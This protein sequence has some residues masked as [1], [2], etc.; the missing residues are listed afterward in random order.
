MS[1]CTGAFQIVRRE[2]VVQLK[3]K[4]LL[5]YHV[6]LKINRIAWN[7]LTAL[8]TTTHPFSSS[9]EPD[10]GPAL[11]RGYDSPVLGLDTLD[12]CLCS[13]LG[14]K[15][16]GVWVGE[17]AILLHVDVIC[18]SATLNIADVIMKKKVAPLTLVPHSVV[19]EPVERILVVRQLDILDGTVIRAN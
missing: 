2:L 7:T 5:V 4:A 18:V 6:S 8:W 13:V 3:E 1:A 17:Q 12:N 9:Q 19:T 10:L 15:D 16:A 14:E 11:I